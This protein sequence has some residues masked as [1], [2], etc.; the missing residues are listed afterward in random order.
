MSTRT[1]PKAPAGA[2]FTGIVLALL[3]I[4]TGVVGIHDLLAGQ[5]WISGSPWLT[6]AITS[7]D[8]VAVAS[9]MVPV[10]VVVA[11]IGL[12]LLLVAIKPRRTTHRP[13]TDAN[14]DLWLSSG[15]LAA[16]ATE[17]A[18]RTPGVASARADARSRRRVDVDVR[19][20]ND[21]EQTRAAVQ[22]AV[23]SRIAPLTTKS[24]RVSVKEVT[25]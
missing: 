3:V 16:M 9:W 18:A 5:G 15:A 25:S 22:D 6:R 8:G 2:T 24:V 12:W 4:A 20:T 17:A 10:A 14:L 1:P 21:T 11:L 13:A 7:L 23:E 19:T